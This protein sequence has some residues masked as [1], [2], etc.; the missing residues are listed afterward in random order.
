MSRV[1]GRNP[2]GQ[3]LQRI[4]ASPNYK[5]GSFQ[6]LSPTPVMAENAS[7][8][9]ILRD[10]LH[11]PK[12]NTPPSTIP[13]VKSNLKML[14]S[15]APVIAWFG[16]SSYLIHI[17]GKNILVDPVFSG[18]ASPFSFSIK[19]Y[20]GSNVYTPEDMPEIDVLVITHD[21]Y[22]H[23]D[24]KTLLQLRPKI[25]NIITSLGVSSHLTYWGFDESKITEM[26]WWNE[27]NLDRFK[28]IAAP[29]R[30][31]SGRSLARGKTLWSG[32]VLQA[33]DYKLF[34]GGDSGYDSHFK[35]IGEKFGPFEIAMLE[36][37]QYNQS[38]PHIHMMPEETVN[39]AT[40]LKAKYLLPVHWAKFS[41]ALHPW[42]EPIKRVTEEAKKWSLPV[43]TPRIGELVIVGANYPVSPWWQEVK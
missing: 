13:S 20:P 6:N 34:L 41:L 16:H 32:F 31:F 24:Y 25:K 12:D 27:M 2:S 35:L 28:F 10:Y 14:H 21:H 30:H 5:N 7:S 42:N 40:D 43:T 19:A 38:W 36:C 1:F 9:K 17:N 15:E 23:M 3:N 26:D 11:K 18:N 37:G 4:S 22:D 8:F 33:G 39:A 29:G